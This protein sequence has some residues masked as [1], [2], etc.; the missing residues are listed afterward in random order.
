MLSRH[1]ARPLEHNW[2]PSVFETSRIQ[3]AGTLVGET[4]VQAGMFYGV[5]KARRHAAPV[6]QTDLLLE[7][8]VNRLACETSGPRLIAGDINHTCEELSQLQRL[9]GLGWQEI[10]DFAAYQ[11]N[12]PQEATGRGTAKL[13]QVWISPELLGSV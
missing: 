6:L 13:D 11:W 3:I 2:E 4:W 5:P 7:Q 8:L 1:P 9:R 10:Q 12:R